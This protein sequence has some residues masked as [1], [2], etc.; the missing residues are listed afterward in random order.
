MENCIFCKI[1]GGEIPAKIA[2]EDADTMA[3]FDIH[4]QAPVHI[5]WVP[6][7]HIAGLDQMDEIDMPLV[8]LLLKNISEYA[9]KQGWGA[10]G[11]RVVTNI[12]ANGRQS[13]RHL[14]FHLLS[15][16]ELSEFLG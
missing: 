6:K 16:R 11:Y 9:R 14:H 7:K 15:G 5:V 13:V 2:Y 8:G 10:Q 4:P 3:F 1:I 12:G